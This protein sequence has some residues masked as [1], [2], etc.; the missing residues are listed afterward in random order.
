MPAGLY[1][2]FKNLSFTL[3]KRCLEIESVRAAQFILS[4]QLGYNRVQPQKENID[5][6]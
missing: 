2:V 3:P 4:R 5:P 6:Y 1:F